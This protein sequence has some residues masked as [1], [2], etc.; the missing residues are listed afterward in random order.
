M[1][2]ESGRR[3]AAE[4]RER[5]IRGLVRLAAIACVLIAGLL[6]GSAQA[7]TTISVVPASPG[8]GNSFPFGEGNI[9]PQMGFIYKNVPAFELKTGDTIAFDLAGMNDADIQ[10][11]IDLAPTT[12]NGG[13]TPVA[14]TNVVPNTELPANPRGDTIHGDFELTF[15]S[16]APFSFAGGGLI[17]R[18]SHPSAAYALDTTPTT[19]L[20]DLATGADPSGFFV[21]RFWNDADGLPPYDNSS[22][23]DI[24]GF[25]LNIADVPP[26]AT[27]TAPPTTIT[28]TTRKKKRCKHR[29]RHHSGAVIAKKCKKKRR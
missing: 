28:T 19:T 11:Q 10:L 15:T 6:T 16:Q 4:V 12:V 13:D 18:F 17:I 22:T 29:K 26:P 8:S 1:R 20:F 25:R 27:T 23:T 2:P 9:W 14:F 7:A 5:P 3:L 24:T 21:K